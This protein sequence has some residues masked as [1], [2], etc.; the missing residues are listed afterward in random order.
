MNYEKAA[1]WPVCLTL[2]L[3]FSFRRKHGGGAGGRERINYK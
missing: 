1:A 2:V 3:C